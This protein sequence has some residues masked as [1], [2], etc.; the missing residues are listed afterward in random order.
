MRAFLRGEAAGGLVLMTAAAAG[1]IAANAPLATSYFEVLHAYA[2][3]LSVLH[4]INDGLMAVFFLIIGLEVKRELIDGQLSTWPRRILPGAAAIGGMLI[5]ALVYLAFARETPGAVK[6][7]A[8]P[9][10][11]DIAFTL[12]VLALLGR[13][14]PVSLKI[15][16]TALAIVDDLGAVASI[17]VFYTAQLSLPWLG[18]AGLIVA[19]LAGL[20]RLRVRALWPYMAGGLLLWICV[21]QSGVHA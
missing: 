10:A 14:V 21:L 11:T 5:P 19:G 7:W 15:F 16:V 9:A 17:A 4:W 1:L 8:T 3:P 12:G 20:N 13:R 2:G 18:A 6:G